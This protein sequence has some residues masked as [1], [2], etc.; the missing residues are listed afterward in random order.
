MNYIKNL[1]IHQVISLANKLNCINAT[2]QP[3]Y[4]GYYTTKKEI[5]YKL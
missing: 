3:T 1:I 2:N 5:Q 4:K